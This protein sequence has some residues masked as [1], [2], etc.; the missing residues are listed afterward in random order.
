MTP[1]ACAQ[2]GPNLV[3]S[4]ISERTAGGCGGAKR[5]SPTGGA[6]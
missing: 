4:K 5:S 2:S 6:A 1:P 3:A